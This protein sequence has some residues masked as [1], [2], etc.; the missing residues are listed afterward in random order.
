MILQ[1]KAKNIGEITTQLQLILSNPDFLALNVD[2]AVKFMK[3]FYS[4]IK[5][6]ND[7]A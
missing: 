7:F 6:L 4:K 1:F 3:Y 2:F 5:L